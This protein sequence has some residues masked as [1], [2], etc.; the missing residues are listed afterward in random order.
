MESISTIQL[1]HKN[2]SRHDEI[3]TFVLNYTGNKYI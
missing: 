2:T 3:L 1:K